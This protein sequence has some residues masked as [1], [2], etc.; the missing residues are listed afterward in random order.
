MYFIDAKVA[1]SIL[2]QSYEAIK[3]AVKRGSDKYQHHYID[4][5][6]RGG[7]KLLIGVTETQ[8]GDAEHLPDI[9]NMLIYN[10]NLEPIDYEVFKKTLVSDTKEKQN[11]PQMQEYLN[12]TP[13]QQR[14]TLL[15][16]DVLSLYANRGHVSA[17]VYIQM[18]DERFDELNITE[19]KLWRWLS[20]L[21]EAETQG[22]SPLIA[23][24]DK[25]GNIKGS[26]TLNKD[27][28]DMALRMRYRRDN[29]LRV[30]AIYANMKHR[31]GDLMPS[32]DVLN[33]FLLEW[34]R[35]NG[36]IHDF[37]EDAD[38]WKNKRMAS[39]G[40][41]NEKA[42]YPNHYWE[43]DSTPAD[44]ITSDGKRWTV[45]CAIDVFSRRAVFW[46]DE[47]SSSYSIARLLRQAILKL[48]IPENVVIDNG[49]DYKSN[50]FESI[51]YNLGINQITVPPFSGDMKPH[52]ER[53]FRTLSTQLFEE[54][55][56]YVGHSV[57]EREKIQSRR[58]F[59]H[60]LESQQK[61]HAEARK[62][63]KKQFVRA[64][65]LKK[66]N[67]GLELNL[68]M[69]YKELDYWIQGWAEMYENRRHGS[70]DCSPLQQWHKSSL[71]VKSIPDPR[72]L[73]ILLGESFI[74]KVGKQGIR[75]QGAIYLH[76]KLAEYVGEHV[77]LMCPDDRG[78]VFVY[79]MNYEPICI[80]EDPELL[81][82]SRE[83]YAGGKKLSRRIAREINK[84]LQE[85]E[86][87]SN[88]H[89]PSI[90]ERIEDAARIIGI[91]P[92]EPIVAVTKPTETIQ[93]VIAAS[94]IFEEQDNSTL[95]ASNIIN[96]EGE[97]LTPSG[98]P[99]FKQLKDRFIWDLV[100][101]RVDESTEKL[102]NKKPD[103]WELAQ[104]EYRHM[105]IG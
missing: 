57:S 30:S 38:G 65:S 92:Q 99:A 22:V 62:E 43:L 53:I 10:E 103:I 12:A 94:K 15:K 105:K 63:T 9:G 34:K 31:Y 18:L 5:K 73:D 1:G 60:K 7:K 52:V 20:K 37:A 33:N 84:M 11:V 59:Q 36:M 29:P 75:L 39:F 79:T 14:I 104:N 69:E 32:Y 96:M 46:L 27:L 86:A 56:G 70:L 90:K 44:V 19:S 4:A 66:E 95:E 41:L 91:T 71:P 17:H 35:C 49:K 67:A 72:M 64:F 47:R 61:W 55:E 3:K 28:Q 2:D 98:R 26:T 6:G 58:G 48:G 76:V 54:M 78:L 89:D 45:L 16:L 81:G 74:R 21:K 97:K 8:L 51:C 77:R 87:Y 100:N 25:R 68:S 93:A 102:S 82:K 42:K 24:L 101:D 80:S 50:H 40:S 88:D 83:E 23:M 13:T 85:W